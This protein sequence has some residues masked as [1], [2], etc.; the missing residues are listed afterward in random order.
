[1]S[2]GAA[3]HAG[4]VFVGATRYTGPLAWLRLAP[5]WLRLVRQMKRMPGYLH[6][7]VY[8]EPPFSLGTLGFFETQD[9]LMRF[10][11]TGEHRELMGWVLSERN[12]RGGYIR[13]Y[14]ADPTDGVPHAERTVTGEGHR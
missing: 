10:A 14:H 3:Q 2:A 6:H 13:I 4:A 12:A 8:Y 7:R 9:D 5:Q 1:V 11:R